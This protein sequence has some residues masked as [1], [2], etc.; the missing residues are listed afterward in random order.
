MGRLAGRRILVTRA[1]GQASALASLLEAEGATVIQIPAIEI[2]APES[3]ASLDE[4]IRELTGYEWLVLTSANA[5]NAMVRRAGE[6]GVS[7]KVPKTAVI[8]PATAAAL[9]AAGLVE[10]VSLMP[11]RFVA[12]D[13][14]EAMV[15]HAAG[16]RMLLV[17]AAVG[18]DVLP[19][20]LRA[21]GA[22]VT[23]VEAYRTVVPVGSVDALRRLFRETGPDAITFTSAST[24]VNLAGLM[25]AAGVGVP[26]G[27]V[28]ASIGPVT[29]RAMR[30]NGM[31]PSFEAVEATVESLVEGMRGWFGGAVGPLSG[32]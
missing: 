14:A 9:I 17:R 7:L 32:G 8:G 6:L 27:T 24:A 20:R 1:R 11:E 31:E 30:G 16:A 25:E 29:S 5:V 3:F 21:A 10:R 2:V 26:E 19:D 28:L 23:I 12:E 4:A 18:R 15:P 13:L 22:S